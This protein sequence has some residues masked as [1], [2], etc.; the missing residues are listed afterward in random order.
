MDLIANQRYVKACARS[1]RA[2]PAIY[3]ALAESGKAAVWK[4]VTRS[5]RVTG[6]NP[7]CAPNSPKGLN[8]MATTMH[9]IKGWLARK[10]D[11]H[12]HMIVV[13]DTFD[14]EDY[15]VFVTKDEDLSEVRAKYSGV[16][17]QR[18]M[19]VYFVPTSNC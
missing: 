3:G 7:V 15:P 9:D 11:H 13:C 5:Q 4:T 12:T 17:M 6:S 19:E 10:E 8:V 2:A 18:V 1:N 14:Y 16:N